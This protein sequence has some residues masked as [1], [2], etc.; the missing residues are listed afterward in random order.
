MYSCIYSPF[1][2]AFLDDEE[3]SLIS[4]LLDYIV[5]GVFISDILVIFISAY[6]DNNLNL[7]TNRKVFEYSHPRKFV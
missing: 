1:K 2:L 6:H 4:S 5:D 3:K 7:I